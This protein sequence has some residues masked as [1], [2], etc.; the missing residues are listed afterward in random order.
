MFL[1]AFNQILLIDMEVVVLVFVV[2]FGHSLLRHSSG[3][4]LGK[5]RNI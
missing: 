5:S 4:I 2:L 1:E 3:I